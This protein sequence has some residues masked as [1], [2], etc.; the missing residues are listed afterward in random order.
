M[1][2]LDK[3]HLNLKKSHS[4]IHS[5]HP[6]TEMLLK[7]IFIRQ[8]CKSSD[9]P[10]GT[11]YHLLCDSL[12]SI[13]GQH[14]NSYFSL[15]VLFTTSLTWLRALAFVGLPFKLGRSG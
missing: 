1:C 3:C 13:P 15:S 10:G 2:L 4:L 8:M 5:T 11:L 14:C 7:K 9:P 6:E 12:L